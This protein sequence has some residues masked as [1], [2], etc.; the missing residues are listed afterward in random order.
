M[1]K[2]IFSLLAIAFMAVLLFTS[3]SKKTNKQGRYIPE[4]AAA[5]MHINGESLN[6]KLP[7]EEI[8]KNEWFTE[9][10]K[11]TSMSAFAKTVLDNP[12]NSGVD[13]KGDI[14][15]FYVSDTSGAYMAIE[16][17]VTDMAKFKAMLFEGNKEG[18]ET[19]KDGYT[20][21]EDENDCVA[22]NKE[23]FFVTIHTSDLT[24]AVNSYDL[25]TDTSVGG[26]EAV[27]D[28]TVKRDMATAASQL[29]ALAEDKSMAKNEKFSELLASKGDA[30]F[31][32]NAKYFDATKNLG[33]MASMANL[34]KLY[35]GAITVG[36]LNFENGKIDADLKS[37]GGKEITELYK[38]YNGTGIDKAMLQ[39]IPSQNVA[40]VFAFN[41]KPE[42]VKEFLKLLNMD[43][44]VNL[45]AAQIGFNLDDFIK[46]NKGDILF[47]AT[48]VV[49][50]SEGAGMDAKFIFA[51]SIGDKPSFNKM[52]DAGKKIGGPMLGA[53][54]DGEKYAFNTNDKYFVFSNDKANADKFLAGSTA[55]APSY[56][57]KIVGGPFGGF[58]NFQYL[59]NNIETKPGTDSASIA[60]QVASLKMWDNMILNGGNFKDGGI[61]QH[62]E[63]NMMDK[64]TNSLK[65]LNTY[66]G[67]MA[68]MDKKKTAAR[69]KQ[70]MEDDI[71]SNRP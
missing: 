26:N 71:L 18:K 7:W 17:A 16:G 63:V 56:I 69:D 2:R 33:A 59:L 29:I 46:A 66:L 36:T 45:G 20:Y 6:A 34:S 22:Y 15:L 24:K 52:I 67:L 50:K 53:A 11:D 31:W 70:W 3:C 13:V 42:G 65:Q 57:D 14:L 44:L 28:L 12:V 38:K 64:S 47:A 4:T 40:G 27:K 62:W 61:T 43:G 23:K 9:M 5:V 1:Q 39:N 51:T 68:A 55:A 49:K 21:F 60:M 8:K 37:Y 48:D 25:S 58:V 32:F 30:H 35:D 19:I 10:Q 54:P 41:F